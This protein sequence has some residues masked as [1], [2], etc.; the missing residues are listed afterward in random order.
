M[1]DIKRRLRALEERSP[2][3]PQAVMDQISDDDLDWLVGLPTDQ[4][5]QQYDFE[6]FS[7]ADRSRADG[8]IA[9]AYA[10]AGYES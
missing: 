9:A 3:L 5:G 8:I 10:A 6:R 1:H 4:S 7:P 2:G